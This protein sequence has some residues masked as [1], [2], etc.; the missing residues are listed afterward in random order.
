[1]GKFVFKMSRQNIYIAMGSLA[2]AITKA[3]GK[4]QEQEKNTI[5]QLAQKEFELNDQDNEWIEHMFTKLEKEGISLDDAYNYALDVLEA[6]RFEFDFDQEM[7]QKCVK[8]M[9]RI[10]E[11]SDGV[12]VNE[13][14][15][16]KK[17]KKDI[18]RF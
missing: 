11:S 8:F 6:N 13:Q 1:M 17:F 10:A 2:Y 3:D 14:L 4:I 16:L 5:K 12:S 15:I 9:E 7:K 18:T